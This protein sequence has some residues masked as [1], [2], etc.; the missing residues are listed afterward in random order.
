MANEQELTTKVQD[1]EK[2][3][4]TAQKLIGEMTDNKMKA[5]FEA[6]IAGLEAEKTALAAR[7]TEIETSETALKDKV[8]GMEKIAADNA[9]FITA[10]KTSFDS[11]RADIKKLSAQV[12]GEAYDEKLIDKQLSA[13]GNDMEALG[14]F[15]KKLESRRGKMFKTGELNPDAAAENAGQQRTPAQQYELGQ[16]LVPKRLTVVK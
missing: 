13:F 1:L 12:D 15:K 6:K 11:A 10:G 9:I 16:K 8:A 7:I 3:L 2:K 5:E 4:E 14:S